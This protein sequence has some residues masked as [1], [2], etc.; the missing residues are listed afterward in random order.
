[1]LPARFLRP[2][3]VLEADVLDMHE[4]SKSDNRYL[5]LVID[6][7]SKFAFAFPLKTKEA[8][9]IALKLLELVRPL[10]YHG[11]FAVIKVRSLKRKLSRT[12]VD[13]LRSL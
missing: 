9:G 1:M 5:L 8:E 6:R 12:F 4:K 2:W 11:R 3:H 7:A 10:E 13:G